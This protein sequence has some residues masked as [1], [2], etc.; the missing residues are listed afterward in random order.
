MEL[1]KNRENE[2]GRQEQR[3]ER[4]KTRDKVIIRLKKNQ[5]KIL[6]AITAHACVHYARFTML[7]Y[8]SMY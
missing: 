7:N 3:R 4:E 1:K 5:K 2:M 6:F 8:K